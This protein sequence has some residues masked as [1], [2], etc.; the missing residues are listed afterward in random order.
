MR[1]AGSDTALVVRHGEMQSVVAE[2][3]RLHRMRFG[4]ISPEKEL[5]VESIE[6]EVIAAAKP[7]TIASA[8]ARAGAGDESAPDAV[9]RCYDGRRVARLPVLPARK[10]GGGCMVAGPRGDSRPDQHH[11]GRARLARATDPG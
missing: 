8:A 5:V 4:F 7:S 1:Y 6:V 9:R 10:F 2:F 3:E 11:R